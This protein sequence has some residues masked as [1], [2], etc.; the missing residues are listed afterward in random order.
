LGEVLL[1][2]GNHL[3]VCDKAPFKD[4]EDELVKRNAVQS[5]I[6][7]GLLKR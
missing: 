5:H 1:A 7:R 3:L 6:L 4:I 2:I